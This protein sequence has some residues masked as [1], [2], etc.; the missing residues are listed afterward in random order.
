MHVVGDPY[1]GLGAEDCTVTAESQVR[2]NYVS[3]S[4]ASEIR[5]AV[6]LH[7]ENSPSTPYVQRYI[8]EVPL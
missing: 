7:A 2:H 4:T 6:C 3:G 8:Y 1:S 5:V